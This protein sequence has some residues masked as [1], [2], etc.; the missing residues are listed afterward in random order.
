MHSMRVRWN[1]AMCNTQDIG[2]SYNKQIYMRVI[3]CIIHHVLDFD[4]DTCFFFRHKKCYLLCETCSRLWY[5]YTF[6]SIYGYMM[7]FRFNL[8]FNFNDISVNISFRIR[9]NLLQSLIDKYFRLKRN[10]EKFIYIMI[11]LKK[12]FFF[13]KTIL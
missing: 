13:I 9:W 5:I 7:M 2:Y 1:S 10:I 3:A 12:I 6:G 11:K 4:C 8:E